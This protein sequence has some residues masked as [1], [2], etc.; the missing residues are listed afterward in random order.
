[1][2]CWVANNVFAIV[3]IPLEGLMTV[4]NQI[5]FCLIFGRV[6]FAVGP[7]KEEGG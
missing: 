2:L 3:E 6:Y 4:L 7:S 1:M 5:V